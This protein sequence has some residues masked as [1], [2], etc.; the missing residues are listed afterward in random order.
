MVIDGRILD[1]CSL[2]NARACSQLPTMR[3]NLISSSARDACIL[4][5]LAF[6]NSEV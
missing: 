5:D 4:I 3:Q 6:I 2:G 1:C